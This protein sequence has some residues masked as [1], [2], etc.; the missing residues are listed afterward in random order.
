VEYFISF[1][2]VFVCSNFGFFFL[3]LFI[4]GKFLFIP[5]EL[6]VFVWIWKRAGNFSNVESFHHIRVLG[7]SF[8]TGVKLEPPLPT[9]HFI[10]QKMSM[11]H[12]GWRVQNTVAVIFPFSP[13]SI[14][15]WSRTYCSVYG[16]FMRRCGPH[17]CKVWK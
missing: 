1:S 12:C 3:Q 8:E 10:I 13:P 7:K 16:I 6:R 14:F 9:K 11:R 2:F 17:L 15:D 4:S 5:L